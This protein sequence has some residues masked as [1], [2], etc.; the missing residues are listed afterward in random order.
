MAWV[1]P[2]TGLLAHI[3][4]YKIEVGAIRKLRHV[5]RGEGGGEYC[6]TMRVSKGASKTT[7][8]A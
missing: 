4:N 3:E 6:V 8:L 2:P 5:S 7:I 1:I